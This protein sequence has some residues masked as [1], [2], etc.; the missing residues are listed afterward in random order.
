M[1]WP[2]QPETRRCL[3]LFLFE[4][5]DGF[6]RSTEGAVQSGQCRPPARRRRCDSS[7]VI[8][9]SVCASQLWLD[10]STVG[11]GAVKHRAID[12]HLHVDTAAVPRRR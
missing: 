8:V 12:G 7:R 11:T 1:L 10:L 9:D 4:N 5:P 6:L 3:V 2:R